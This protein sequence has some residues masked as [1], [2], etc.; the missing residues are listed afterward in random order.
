MTN[1]NFSLLSRQMPSIQSCTSEQLHHPPG[2]G[3]STRS[4]LLSLAQQHWPGGLTFGT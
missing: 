1:S 3:V 2:R 4:P